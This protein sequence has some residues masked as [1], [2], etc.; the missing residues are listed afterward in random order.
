M[1]WL[2]TLFQQD[3]V[4]HSIVVIGLV[5]AVG[6]ALGHIK[7]LGIGLG[8][9]GVLFA[10][11]ISS[12]FG[13][14]VNH[15]VLEFV[16]ELGLVFFVFTIGLQL[17]PGFFA[18]L[19]RQ[20]LKMNAMAAAIV[21]LGAGTVLLIHRFAGVALPAA[22]GL[23]SGATTNTPSLAASGQVLRQLP[24]ISE[25]LLRLPDLAYAIAYPFGIIGTIL[26]MVAI[27]GMFRIDVE[28]EKRVLKEKSAAE[29][30]D[31]QTLVLRVT[32]P[33][34]AGVAIGAIPALKEAGAVVS[35]IS[36]GGVAEVAR[37]D[38]ALA[39]GDEILAVASPAGLEKL[40]LVIG[41]AS[42][43]DLRTAPGNV[44]VRRVLVTSR[45][46]LGKTV[47]ELDLVRRF[48]V[49][50][51]RIARGD[52]QFTPT[53]SLRLQFADT[54]TIVGPR[55]QFAEA[56]KVLGNSPKELNQPNLVPIFI[57]IMLGVLLGSVPWFVPGLP[58]PVKLGLAGGPLIVAILLA[59]LGHWG[60]LVWYMPPN[61]NYM[62]REIGIAL[63][64]ACV[65]LKSGDSFVRILSGGD[66]LRWILCGALITVVPLLLVGVLARAVWKM[67]YIRLC[68]LLAGSM[69]DP[70][71]LAFAT[72]LS[73]S[74]D[75]ALSYVTVYPLTM[76]L[77]VFCAQLLALF[78]MA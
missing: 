35:R 17:G 21:L 44:D 50:V 72:S 12:H 47:D 77:R 20:G 75:V 27:R 31:I 13:L 19:R 38:M 36:R 23:F 45:T 26:V 40:R 16:R 24:G 58:A 32:N 48:G 68:G 52:Q 76:I 10:G 55:D 60:P 34:L 7:V 33:N 63:F 4:A 18:S 30:R 39:L 64:L 56:E 54:L 29:R 53:D 62:L 8:V 74:E 3:S 59:R 73:G 6:L 2:I 61:A 14:T 1:D 51:T 67:N 66:G 65:G 78:F 37:P 41:Q 71:A 28:A 69:T 9:A 5:I 25:E 15:H 57:G 70:P 11:L 42:A 22:L 49:N 46:A 43:V